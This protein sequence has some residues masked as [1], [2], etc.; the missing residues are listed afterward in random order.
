LE[1]AVILRNVLARAGRSG[2]GIPELLREFEKRRYPRVKR[3]YDNQLLRYQQRMTHG[4]RVGRQDA[5][6][7]EWLYHSGF[8]EYEGLGHDDEDYKAL[9]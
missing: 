2:K 8:D 1:D 9:F 6:F 7:L 3:V 5:D 4:I